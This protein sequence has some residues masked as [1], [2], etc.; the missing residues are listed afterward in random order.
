[1]VLQR[2]GLTISGGALRRGLRGLLMPHVLLLFLSHVHLALLFLDPL[3]SHLTL[4]LEVLLFFLPHNL[5][6]VGHLLLTNALCFLR[7]SS[8]P[9]LVLFSEGIQ[10]SSGVS[11][12]AQLVL[13]SLRMKSGIILI[14]DIFE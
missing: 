12:L 14:L 6:F 8:K 10:S 2:L 3:K 13:K 11:D 4:V 1:L 9:F 5:Q 7:F